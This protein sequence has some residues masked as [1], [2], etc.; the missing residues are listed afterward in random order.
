MTTFGKIK[1]FNGEHEEWKHY[2][3]RMN[4]FFE[5]NE[6]EDEGKQRSIF[7]VS[8][9]AKTYKL[10]RSLVAPEEP[11][12]KSYEELAKLVQDHYQPKPSVIVERFKFNTR[13]QQQGETI[14]IY[15]AELKR[16][17]ENCELGS[18]L[19]EM[20]R[21]RIVCGTSDHRIQRRLLAEPKL[22]LK[23]ALDLAIAIETSEKDAFITQE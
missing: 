11:K 6:I 19:N 9:G 22:T 15:S 8:V 1:E 13:C 18:N 7:L 10:I 17:S 14:P 16:L 20:L 4:H 2:I 21:D 23:R 5:A 12:S 3:E